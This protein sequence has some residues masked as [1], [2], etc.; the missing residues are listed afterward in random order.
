NRDKAR[1]FREFRL[2]FKDIHDFFDIALAEAVLVAVLHETFRG[3]DH[4][5]APTAC[6]VF[7][8]EN[9]DAGWNS[10]A[11]EQICRQANDA[12]DISAFNDVAADLAL[13]TTTKEDPV[14]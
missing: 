9:D 14:W 3:V 2:S 1:I 12:L 13:C 5:D 11:V 8:V 10:R 7:F 4:K 6:S